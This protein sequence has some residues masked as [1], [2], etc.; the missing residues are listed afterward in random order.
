MLSRHRNQETKA[1]GKR[2]R[3][4][5]LDRRKNRQEVL[6][7]RSRQG[8]H[9]IRVAEKNTKRH[10]LHFFTKSRPVE[11]QTQEGSPAFLSSVTEFNSPKNHMK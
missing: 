5:M 1:T 2:T 9:C 3:N 11:D 4:F 7:P 6:K 8:Q 10:A